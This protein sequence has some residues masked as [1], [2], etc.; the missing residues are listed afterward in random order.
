MDLESRTL[1]FEARFMSDSI[2]IGLDR[3]EEAH[4]IAVIRKMLKDTDE[5]SAK[6]QGI[7]ND[8]D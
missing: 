1:L 7:A 2:A 5:L 8:N 4:E 6:A 3:I